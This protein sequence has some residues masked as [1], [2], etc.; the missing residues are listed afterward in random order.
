MHGNASFND[1]VDTNVPYQLRGYMVK[2]RTRKEIAE[3]AIL[4]YVRF[5]RRDLNVEALIDELA[6]QDIAVHIESDRDWEKKH[7]WF[8]SGESE[9]SNNY[10]VIPNRVFRGAKN[11]QAD[12][13]EVFFHELGHVVLEHQPIYMKSDGYVLS[14]YDDAEGQADLFAEF[15][16]RLFGI[17]VPKQLTLF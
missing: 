2:K 9:P 10:I 15:M 11:S 1:G 8:K 7:T 5:K 14:E 16:L 6:E 4:Q 13:L 12:S 17:Y 3:Q